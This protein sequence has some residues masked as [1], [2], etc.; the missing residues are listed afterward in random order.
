MCA[1]RKQHCWGRAEHAT[2]LCSHARTAPVD[3]VL[4]LLLI[5]ALSAPSAPQDF[6]HGYE[7]V[8]LRDATHPG[9]WVLSGACRVQTTSACAAA[10]HAHAAIVHAQRSS[11]AGVTCRGGATDAGAFLDEAALL[12]WA[13]CSPGPCLEDEIFF[14]WAACSPAPCLDDA[15]FL[16]W[17]GSAA[18][19]TME[20]RLAAASS[21]MG[22]L[23]MDALASTGYSVATIPIMRA[24]T[25]H[26]QCSAEA[27]HTA[28]AGRIFQRVRTV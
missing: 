10:A 24:Q 26:E 8:P 2:H 13:G 16:S 1:H 9:S 4:F 22:A 18:A 6:D 27:M 11:E 7:R 3:V 15:A 20:G 19:F 23:R 21:S 5:H 25:C 14:S 28:F 17:A 12:S